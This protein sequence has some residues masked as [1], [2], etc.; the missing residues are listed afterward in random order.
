MSSRW[1]HCQDCG[2]L[3][4]YR[5]RPRNFLEK[6]LLPLTSFRPVR[7]GDCFRRTYQLVFCA[8]P[9]PARGK[10]GK[11]RGGLGRRCLRS[12]WPLYCE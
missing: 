12:G 9:T 10:K 6:Y 7:C 11:Q 2:G 1:F 4:G 8:G 3:T 5:S